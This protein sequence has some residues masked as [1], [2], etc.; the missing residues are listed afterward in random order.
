MIT[1]KECYQHGSSIGQQRYNTVHLD[2]FRA[3]LSKPTVMLQCH[4]K[5]SFLFCCRLECRSFLKWWER[6]SSTTKTSSRRSG[7]S[8]EWMYLTMNRD[9]GSWI[10]CLQNMSH[11]NY[12][13]WCNKDHISI[14][15]Q[16]NF[17]CTV[18]HIIFF[19]F[20]LTY[21]MTVATCICNDLYYSMTNLMVLCIRIKQVALLYYYRYTHSGILLWW[22]RDGLILLHSA[23]HTI[24]RCR[25]QLHVVRIW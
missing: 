21:C 10:E 13:G 14:N 9:W 3:S 7:K 25:D 19:Q 20:C 8:W 16:T 2:Y 1:Q 17:Y 15:V 18:C 6:Q 24:M 23:M 22:Y 5:V 4:L 12:I 11:E